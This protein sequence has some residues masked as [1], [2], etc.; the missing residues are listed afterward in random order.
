[1]LKFPFQLRSNNS[2]GKTG[3]AYSVTGHDA[4]V[5]LS[6]IPQSSVSTPLPCIVATEH[7]LA[8][9]FLLQER[10][11]S[12]D[13]SSIRLVSHDSDG[14]F[15][16][17]IRFNRAIAHFFGPPNNEAFRGHPLADRGLEPYGAYEITS[18]S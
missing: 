5:P 4:V 18:S 6:D 13:G 17:V 1:M 15:I 16:G 7:S 11:H 10:D 8:V 14:E 2:V 3:G 9:A 12:W